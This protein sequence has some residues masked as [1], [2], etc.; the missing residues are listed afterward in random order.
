MGKR[1]II[2]FTGKNCWI[3]GHSGCSSGAVHPPLFSPSQCV[4]E[5]WRHLMCWSHVFNAVLPSF[6]SA[7]ASPVMHLFQLKISF[8]C[9]LLPQPLHVC[10][11]KSKVFSSFCFSVTVAFVLN[12]GEFCVFLCNLLLQLEERCASLLC[13]ASLPFSPSS[14]LPERLFSIDALTVKCSFCLHCWPHQLG[15]L[16]MTHYTHINRTKHKQSSQSYCIHLHMQCSRLSLSL[17]FFF[18]LPL[19]FLCLSFSLSVSLTNACKVWMCVEWT[20]RYTTVIFG[21][22]NGNWHQLGKPVKQ[23]QFYT[24]AKW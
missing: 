2:T 9:L 6:I 13:P 11:P 16:L 8:P 14:S 21:N 7:S 17:F 3:M 12:C 4:C 15:Q 20:V 1:I 19:S 24:S 5:V 22:E 18:S 23:P 10:L